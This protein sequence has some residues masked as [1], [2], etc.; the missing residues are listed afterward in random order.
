MAAVIVPAN[1]TAA[2][3]EVYFPDPVLRE[4]IRAAIGGGDITQAKLDLLTSFSYGS[5][6]LPDITDL[7]GM[8]YCTSLTELDLH[9]NQINDISPL[10]N[11][12]ALE[13]LDLSA[14]N[15]I[16]DISVLANLTNLTRL[17][18]LYIEQISD[19]SPLSALTSLD[20]LG[21][22]ENQ[23]T[24]ISPL[25]SLT[26]LTWLFLADNQISDITPL[27]GLSSLTRLSL[28][29]NPISDLSPLSDLTSLEHLYLDRSQISDIT[30]LSDLT[31]LYW[32]WAY[33]NQ[34]SDISALSG[35]TNLHNLD[36]DDNQISDITALANLTSLYGLGLV[37][38][39]IS[40]I[41]AL[42]GL[43]D[44][45]TLG[46]DD[47]QISDITALA[48]LTSLY[49]LTLMNNQISDISALSGLTNNLH[50]L[51]LDDNQISDITALA[52]LTSLYRLTLM[53]N[54]ISN[55][56]AL[57][58]NPGLSDGDYIDIR[59]N[60]LDYISICTYI[61]QLQNRGVTVYYTYSG[62]CTTP[63][64]V[65]TNPA[66]NIFASSASLN[67]YLD[68]L[69]T[70]SLVDVSFV[71]VTDDYYTTHNSTYSSET[72]PPWTTSSIGPVAYSLTGLSP[73]TTYHVRAKS[74]GDG[75][76]HG[77][78]L[79]F[80]TANVSDDGD[81]VPDT[82]EDSA[83]NGGDGNNDTIPDSQQEHVASFPNAEDGGYVTIESLPGTSFGNVSAIHE[84][85][86]PTEG[87]PSIE[88]PFGFFAFDIQGLALG[89]TIDVTLTLDKPVPTDTEYWKYGPTPSNHA[90]HWY[91]IPMGSDDGDNVI[92]ITLK[93]GGLGDDWWI[94]DGGIVDQGGPGNGPRNGPV[95]GRGVPVFPS[96]YI[97]ILAALGAGIV[98]YLYRRKA[99]GRRTTET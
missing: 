41:A 12:V 69:G 57:V 95:S 51:G 11:L 58:T 54:Q 18:L 96:I 97:G 81:G 80:T 48:N 4:A 53:N 46:L 13:D 84:N 9:N 44:L 17:R 87:K 35:L 76:A 1:P 50:N 29:T 94:E 70:A 34:I 14:N 56:E 28:G 63:P 10:T 91:Q 60:P 68:I 71:W 75:I 19:I 31:N 3:D 99:L 77:D 85:T 42:S 6:N 16:S 20:Y 8:E 26:N 86:L 45:Q 23:I 90:P 39:Q 22:V 24:N 21:L 2:Q 36:L 72:T 74:V 62:P 15:Q 49:R 64:V 30:A 27:S 93:D 38:N 88:F 40:D 73:N 32:L 89:A 66:T 65:I 5:P 47:N 79:I 33:N 83:P 98:A 61:P 7:A 52:N 25:S 82:V 55:I 37:N 67:G 43:T 92:T 78:D 59:D